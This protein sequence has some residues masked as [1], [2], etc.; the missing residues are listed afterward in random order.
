MS[1]PTLI[2]SETDLTPP[3]MRMWEWFDMWALYEEWRSRNATLIMEAAAADD[4]EESDEE[5][6]KQHDFYVKHFKDGMTDHSQMSA[7]ERASRKK[8]VAAW[9]K[10]EKGIHPDEATRVRAG[11]HDLK[12]ASS[13]FHLLTTTLGSKHGH[14]LANAARHSREDKKHKGDHEEN[15]AEVMAHLTTRHGHAQ[16]EEDPENLKEIHKRL[17]ARDAHKQAVAAHN[18]ANPKD[19]KRVTVDAHSEHGFRGIARDTGATEDEVRSIHSARQKGTHLSPFRNLAKQML[20][21]AAKGELVTHEEVAKSGAN[22]IKMRNKALEG[23]DRKAA[24]LK[25]A[26]EKGAAEIKGKDGE[27]T[28]AL[29]TAVDTPGQTRT[30]LQMAKPTNTSP[31]LHHPSSK[32]AQKGGETLDSKEAHET[33]ATRLGLKKK[34]AAINV[35]QAISRLYKKGDDPADIAKVL[36]TPLATVEG[37][38]QRKRSGPGA[39]RNSGGSPSSPV[40]T[41]LVGAEEQKKKDKAG[42]P[43]AA[44]QRDLHDLYPLRAPAKEGETEEEKKKRHDEFAEKIHRM[45]HGGAK[46]DDP[47]R[48]EV[49]PAKP[50]AKTVDVRTDVRYKGKG[51][52]G[53]DAKPEVLGTHGQP[54]IAHAGFISGR[55]A[56][57]HPG[58]VP[59]DVSEAKKKAHQEK[60]DKFHELHA[61]AHEGVHK[62]LGP[63]LANIADPKHPENVRHREH[64]NALRSAELSG[65][66]NR[67]DE[68]KK[69]GKEKKIHDDLLDHH[70]NHAADNPEVQQALGITGD[71]ARN[72]TSQ[73]LRNII[74]RVEAHGT[75]YAKVAIARGAGEQKGR[76]SP[77]TDPKRRK[78]DRPGDPFSRARVRV[79]ESGA[80]GE[81]G[82]P[83]HKPEKFIEPPKSSTLVTRVLDTRSQQERSAHVPGTIKTATAADRGR[84]RLRAAAVPKTVSTMPAG[85]KASPEAQEKEAQSK[86]DIKKADYARERNLE[87]GKAGGVRPRGADF[88]TLQRVRP[89]GPGKELVQRAASGRSAPGRLRPAPIPKLRTEK[90]EPPKRPQPK[91]KPA[92]W[93][94]GYSS[95]GMKRLRGEP[96]QEPEAPKETP[97]SARKLALSSP[98][99]PSPAPKKP[100]KPEQK[101]AMTNDWR[102]AMRAKVKPEEASKPEEPK[103]PQEKT[104]KW[105]DLA[106]GTRGE[107]DAAQSIDAPKVTHGETTVRAHHRGENVKPGTPGAAYRVATKLPNGHLFS[108][109]VDG[110]DVSHAYVHGETGQLLPHPTGRRTVGGVW[111][112]SHHDHDDPR[113]HD[114]AMRTHR[115]GL[116]QFSSEAGHLLSGQQKNEGLL[117]RRGLALDESKTTLFSRLAGIV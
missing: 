65:D 25:G 108:T 48:A 8:E 61:T 60:L 85:P 11:G 102:A 44:I 6:Q 89:A 75:H 66:T 23:S 90:P 3:A 36:K 13:M 98:T 47:A 24:Q 39:A 27:S 67:V 114:A 105:F 45:Y 113:V 14:I 9:A 21:K 5:K 26:V 17:D 70:L 59:A 87:P 116:H 42:N 50:H 99:K 33:L 107:G 106:G 38:I 30:A 4:E 91:P 92:P 43:S 104:R 109:A 83:D 68:L 57:D 101:A 20:A 31:L 1:A 18:A 51:K 103:A 69:E 71:K 94:A 63:V 95:P 115:A 82:T 79:P 22:L 78:K 19:K 72:H 88:D 111:S 62:A 96:V 117:V 40:V 12:S 34:D 54:T 112:A 46:T 110:A 10:D 93:E 2:N 49:E 32:E 16:S 80:G 7:E 64:H 37:R 15:A 52:D 55:G 41:K 56:L 76:P 74:G 84:A 35:H 77:E 100:K 53:K 97:V 73:A 28:T 86:A 81:I 58:P 29:D